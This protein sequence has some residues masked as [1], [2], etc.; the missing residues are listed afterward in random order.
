M[1]RCGGPQ[2]A[3]TQQQSACDEFPPWERKKKERIPHGEKGRGR[4]PQKAVGQ[5]AVTEVQKKIVLGI[6]LDKLQTVGGG[7]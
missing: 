4:G 7:S 2:K 3:Q 5:E 6:A 1:K